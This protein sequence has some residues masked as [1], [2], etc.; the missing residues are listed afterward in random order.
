MNYIIAVGVFQSLMAMAVLW[1]SKQKRPA[2]NLLLWLVACVFTH[3]T[4][5]FIIFTS[6]EYEE[7]KR[8]LV[9]F[10]GLAYGP[11]L[12]MY[13]RK[14]HDHHYQ[15]ARHWYVLLPSSLAAFWY[16]FIVVFIMITGKVPHPLIDA[17]NNAMVFCTIAFG[18][19]ALLALRIS[20]KVPDFWSMEKKL[21]QHISV[22][23]LVLPASALVL[24]YGFDL[25]H[26][27][28]APYAIL[29]RSIVYAMLVLMVL[30]V[31]H[32]KLS[33]HHLMTRPVTHEEIAAHAEPEPM[34]APTP[35][36]VLV[37]DGEIITDDRCAKKHQAQQDIMQKLEEKMQQEKLYR[38]A[39]LTLEKL[40]ANL[41]LSRNHISEVLNQFAGKSFYQYINEYR[42]R[43]VIRSLDKCRSGSVIPNLLLLAYDAGFKSKSSFN[44]YFKKI[45]HHTPSEY[46]RQEQFPLVPKD[47]L[48]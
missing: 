3:L 11:L 7:I 23:F 2:D 45:T 19:F 6:V 18:G 4:F 8:Q 35:E 25:F 43:E 24:T 31:A 46:L 48:A 26:I 1:G 5:K 29:Y 16:M 37:V 47:S 13:A 41:G 22:L 32:Y 38:D 15:P 12:W 30:R 34:P 36:L 28:G 14:V 17:Y 42:V 40:S 33:M 27:D 9:T 21:L 10:I 39:D 44:L 20:R